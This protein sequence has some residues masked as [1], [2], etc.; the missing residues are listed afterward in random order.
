VKAKNWLALGLLMT[1]FMLVAGFEIH[2]MLKPVPM[3]ESVAI[4]VATASLWIFCD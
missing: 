1:Q 2:E 3:T 4:A